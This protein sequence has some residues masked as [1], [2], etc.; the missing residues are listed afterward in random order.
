MEERNEKRAWKRLLKRQARRRKLETRL[1]QA[2]SRNDSVTEAISRKELAEFVKSEEHELLKTHPLLEDCNVNEYD[3]D[4]NTKQAQGHEALASFQNEARARREIELLYKRLYV[5]VQAEQSTPQN[6]ITAK[7]GSHLLSDD[8]LHL[9]DAIKAVSLKRKQTAEARMLLHNMTKGTQTEDMFENRDAL[10]GYTRQKFQ[11]RAC[12][13]MS[14]L[15]KLDPRRYSD[16]CSFNEHICEQEQQQQQRLVPKDD[17]NIRMRQRRLWDRLTSSSVRSICSIGCGP[18]CDVAGIAKFL[19]FFVPREQAQPSRRRPVVDNIIFLDWTMHRW[20]S[21]LEPLV[22]ELLKP[23]N[24]CGSA[25]MAHCDVLQHLS[26]DCNAAARNLLLTPDSKIGDDFDGCNTDLFVTSYLLTET[27]ERWH[28]FY[29][30]LVRVAK[31]GALFLF[32]EPKA[33]QLHAFIHRHVSNME[34]VWLDSSSEST[35]MQAMEGRIG[36]A[37]LLCMKRFN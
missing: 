14:S 19:E 7:T 1:R 21:F 5:L 9:T 36:P 15:C 28:A 23:T 27:R 6:E 10:M 37:V 34:I 17:Q 18:G 13:A 3:D 32:A 24:V 25:F 30:D 16:T 29:S 8:H 31:P 11:E 35:H 26:A 12:L 22:E 20:R 2:V 4:R 33:W